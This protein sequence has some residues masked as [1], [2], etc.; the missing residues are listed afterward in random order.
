MI[1]RQNAVG[2]LMNEYVN[3]GGPIVTRFNAHQDS[4]RGT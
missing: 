1:P 4:L 3:W 2:R